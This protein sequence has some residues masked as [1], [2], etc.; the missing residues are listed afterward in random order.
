MLRS[1]SM[2]IKG[3]GTIL[4]LMSESLTIYD[5]ALYYQR[6]R[7]FETKSQNKIK[8][9]SYNEL[10]NIVKETE[11]FKKSNMDYVLKQEQIRLVCK[12]WKSFI[13]ATIEYKKN[14]NKFED[15]PK[16]PKYLYRRKKYST[17]FIDKTRFRSVKNNTFKIPCTDV[18]ISCPKHIEHNLIRLVSIQPYYGKVKINFLYDDVKYNDTKTDVKSA[19]GID[20]G[21]NNLCAITINDKY[22]SYV[23]KGGS[24]KSINQFYNKRKSEIVSELMKCNKNQYASH[25][26]DKLN[27]KRKHKI[28]NY[29]HNV[30]NQIIELCL[31][32]KVSKI[33]VGHNKGWKQDIKLGNKKETRKRNNQNF[34]SI[35][36]NDLIE[37]LKYKTEKYLY[38]DLFIVEESYTSKCDHLVKETMEHHENYL[39]KRVKR[40]LFKSSTGKELNADINGAIGIL[41]KG[42]AISDDQIKILR[43]RGDIVSP[44]VLN[45]N[46]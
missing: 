28:Y 24:L 18:I 2:I 32:N 4:R 19:I 41:R 46:P 11:I 3:N 6:Q 45:I 20:I 14:Q 15:K 27:M 31:E 44:K 35:P 30:A 21:L 33:Y 1:C 34:V 12:N 16:M 38:L 9:Y 13:K 5:Q 7:Y 26:I 10:Y 40:G 8:T 17:V 43:D 37:T 42:N 39:G 22:L 25:A 29:I 23:I 36:F